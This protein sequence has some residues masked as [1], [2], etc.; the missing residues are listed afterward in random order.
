LKLSAF[1]HLAF[2]D[3]NA[4]HNARAGPARRVRKHA[5]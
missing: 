4:P 1:W 5:A 3:F 2:P